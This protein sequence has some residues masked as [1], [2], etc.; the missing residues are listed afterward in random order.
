MFDDSCKLE[1]TVLFSCNGT[2][3]TPTKLTN[4]TYGC[5]LTSPDNKCKDCDPQIK[6]ATDALGA[7][8]LL[9]EKAVKTGGSTAVVAAI[10]AKNVEKLK[11]DLPLA[12]A[13]A[14]GLGAIAGPG[15]QLVGAA[16]D[17][18]D[19]LT[20]GTADAAT[21]TLIAALRA[22]VPTLGAVEEC[23]GGNTTDCN[24]I[25]QLYK[26]IKK[27]AFDLIK[28]L[29][30]TGAIISQL[31]NATNSID[32]ALETGSGAAVGQALGVLDGVLGT[33][34]ALPLL[35]TALAPV[36]ALYEAA[37]AAI[38]CQ[39]K[40]SALSFFEV[41]IVSWKRS[42]CQTNLT[43]N[44]YLTCF[45]FPLVGIDPDG[46]KCLIFNKRFEGALAGLIDLIKVNLDKIPI[47]GKYIPTPVLDALKEVLID[48]QKGGAGTIGTAVGTLKGLL[49]V[50]NLAG[51][52]GGNDLSNPITNAI[53]SILGIV[54][55]AGD[56][57]TGGD[58]CSG[59][60]KIAKALIASA[61]NTIGD[62]IPGA[63]FVTKPLI[64]GFLDPLA[65][66]LNTVSGAAIDAAVTALKIPGGLLKA[67]VPSI[68]P[69]V[70]TLIGGLEM[71]ARCLT[72]GGKANVAPSVLPTTVPTVIPTTV[73]TTI[74][75]K[76]V[77]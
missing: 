64:N 70:D 3:T 75:T 9:L 60:I 15:K 68:G 27:T 35:K 50:L 39:R 45:N 25:I 59:V 24:S 17:L 2:G 72:T 56:C 43:S 38:K 71:V 11:L 36:T 58:P 14:L 47:F 18:L 61:A 67:A 10:L 32:T 19:K 26:D 62:L 74:P 37:K 31:E 1:K 57:A 51:G 73:P 42:V 77:S 40:D 7:V 44:F 76:I 49:Q 4:C 53:L 21:T 30:G 22:L 69:A 8:G 6:N 29:P 55:G 41:A 52:K 20:N 12:A 63:N 23:A 28:T 48:V 54:D 66:A 33:L 46:D 65:S 13:D 34:T 16:S 5:E